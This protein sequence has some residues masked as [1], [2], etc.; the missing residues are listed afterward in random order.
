[1][2]AHLSILLVLALPATALASSA[3]THCEAGETIVFSC[4]TGTRILS[5]CASP[6]VSKTSGYLQY[7]YGVADKLEL[8]FPEKL[9]PPGKLFTPGTLAFSGGGGAYL[10]FKKGAY[11]YTVFSA[12]GNWAA[13]G[14]KAT[15]EGIAVKSGDN[16][17]ANFPCRKDA[18]YVEGELGPDYFEKAG[19]GEP[20]S[21]FDIPEA[22]MPK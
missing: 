4:S 9:Q 7:R 19:L 14:G 16:E 5:L 11:T 8:V 2:R 15:A 1:M 12:I 18:N 6:D 10:Q 22:F 13:S 21:D 17:I 20:Q 3:R